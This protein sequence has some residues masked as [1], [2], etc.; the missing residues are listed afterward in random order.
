[1]LSLLLACNYFAFRTEL[2]SEEYEQYHSSSIADTCGTSFSMSTINWETFDKDNAPKAI[3]IE[4]WISLQLICIAPEEN[5]PWNIVPQ[6]K[7]LI[8][9]KSPPL[10]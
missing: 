9:D 2:F 8:R 5:I 1:M 3:K 4:P 10:I 7:Q 6:P